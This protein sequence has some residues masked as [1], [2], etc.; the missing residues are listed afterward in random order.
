MATLDAA[1]K[2]LVSRRLDD[3]TIILLTL[4]ERY[5]KVHDA[6]VVQVTYLSRDLHPRSSSRNDL[7]GGWTV[8]RISQG[9]V[10]DRT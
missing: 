4:N 3:V 6:G 1:L 9:G 5:G 10:P 2:A 8:K 7:R